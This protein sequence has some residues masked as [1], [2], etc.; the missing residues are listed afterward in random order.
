M[1]VD[2]AERLE[3]PEDYWEVLQS[4]VEAF[5]DWEHFNKLTQEPAELIVAATNWDSQRVGDEEL[6][7]E[8]V[9][10]K[11]V[12]DGFVLLLE[13]EDEFEEELAHKSSR[14]AGRV[15]DRGVD[16]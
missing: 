11:Q 16:V 15:E 6:I 2:G 1:T 12:V 9:D 5:D 8:L 4:A 10:V 3:E 14:L 13:A 7:E